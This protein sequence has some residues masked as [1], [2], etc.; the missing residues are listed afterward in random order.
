VTRTAVCFG[1]ALIDCFPDR[2]VVAGAPL[3]VAVH[4]ARLGW[5]ASLA[6]RVGDDEDGRRIHGTLERFGVDTALVETDPLLATGTVR[7]ELGGGDGP[8]FGIGRPAAWD[9]IVGPA[10]LPEADAFVYGTLA[11]RDPRSAATLRRLLAEPFRGLRVLDVNLRPPDYSEESVRMTL[12]AAD[13][14]KLNGEELEAVAGLLGFEPRPADYFSFAPRLRWLCVTLGEQG[15]RLHARDGGAWTV[16]AP[17][18]A[19][20]VDTVGA[21]DAFTAGLVDGLARGAEPED[22]FEAA[23]T[24]AGEAVGHRG[25]LPA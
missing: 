17:E 15:A 24:L 3:H 8:R 25:G 16:A 22:V 5:R 4:L 18:T 20:V 2:R 6:T 13:V 21:G 9:A 11:A 14:L 1:E 19:T 10:Q 23:R 7:I 12:E